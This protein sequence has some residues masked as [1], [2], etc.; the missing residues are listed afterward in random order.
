VPDTPRERNSL[1]RRGFAGD[2]AISFTAR[3]AL[4]SRDIAPAAR[5]LRDCVR[6]M[7]ER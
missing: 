1:G 6:S 4:C 3:L 2:Q 7:L 5:N